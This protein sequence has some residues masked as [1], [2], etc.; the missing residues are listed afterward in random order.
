MISTFNLKD[1][2]S[3]KKTLIFF[4]CKFP[5]EKGRFKYSTGEKIHPSDW[6]QKERLPHTLGE[7]KAID[8]V[9]IKAQ[10]GRYESVFEQTKEQYRKL[11]EDFTSDVLKAAFDKEFKKTPRTKD[12]FFDRYDEFMSFNQ[13]QQNWSLSTVKRYKNIKN[14]LK[15]FEKEKKYTLTFTAITDRFHAEFTDYCMNDLK[16]INNTYSRNLG[17]FK[18]FMFWALKNKH[19]YNSAFVGFEKKKRVITK[20]IALSMLDIQ[21]ILTYDY[22]NERLERVR[23]VFVFACVTGMRFGELKLITKNDIVGNNFILKEEKESEKQSR[24]IP[25]SDVAISILRKYDYKLPLIANQKYNEYIKEVFKE[26]GYTHNVVKNTT[27][28]KENIKEVIPFYDRISSH[29]ARRTFITL[30]KKDKQS[31]KLIASISGHRDLKTL[32][33]YYQVD[34]QDKEEAVNKTFALDVGILKKVN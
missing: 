34:D 19:T 21:T 23:D 12:T 16:H 2:K 28:G 30:M 5:N 20:Q 11:G 32:N 7:S 3:T 9:S 31:D 14:I 29:T 33:Q 22:K 26:A 1:P 15:N 25:L 8:R 6:N 13:K 18:T 4:R 17:L 27:R 10:L 24:S